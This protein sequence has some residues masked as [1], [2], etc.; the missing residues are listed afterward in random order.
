M[1]RRVNKPHLTHK[2]LLLPQSSLP[3]PPTD[4]S[5]G[6]GTSD[7][8]EKGEGVGRRTAGHGSGVLA[9]V[10]VS[11]HTAGGC[12]LHYPEAIKVTPGRCATQQTATLPHINR[13]SVDPI[14][15]AGSSYL[16]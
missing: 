2:A 1:Y 15:A 9:I 10:Q 8:R 12:H 11:C 3:S 7:R 16:L 14:C 13:D 4:T 6:P 5:S